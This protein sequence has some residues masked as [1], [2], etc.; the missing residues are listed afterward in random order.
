MLIEE[1]ALGLVG[2]AELHKLLL[3]LSYDFGGEDSHVATK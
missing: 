1:A 2:I 3:P